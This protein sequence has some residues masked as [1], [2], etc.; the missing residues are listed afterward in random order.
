[1]F[2]LGFLNKD[3]ALTREA[4]MCLPQDLESPSAEQINKTV[5]I[6]HD[7]A[8]HLSSKRGANVFLGNQGYALSSS[9]RERGQYNGFRLY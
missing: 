6:F 1:M 8:K 9:K 4:E 7:E 5:V 2:T 3:N